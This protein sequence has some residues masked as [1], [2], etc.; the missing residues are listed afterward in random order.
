MI[1]STRIS[2]QFSL[3]NCFISFLRKSIRFMKLLEFYLFCV[4]NKFNIV[5]YFE[6]PLTWMTYGKIGLGVT[7]E[8][9]RK[10]I[11]SLFIACSFFVPSRTYSEKHKRLIKFVCWSVFQQ[12]TIL[13]VAHQNMTQFSFEDTN[14][15]EYWITCI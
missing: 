7:K 9:N 8:E 1:V 3:Y 4:R 10:K 13:N 15:H 6:T 5:F 2:Y 14:M 11:A 12:T